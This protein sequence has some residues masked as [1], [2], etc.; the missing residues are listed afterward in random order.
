MQLISFRL[1]LVLYACVQRYSIT[2]EDKNFWELN[3]TLR[4]K[5]KVRKAWCLLGLLASVNFLKP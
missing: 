2:V 5:K 3:T 1:Y 4:E